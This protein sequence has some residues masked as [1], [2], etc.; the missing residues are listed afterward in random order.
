MRWYLGFLFFIALF[1][2]CDDGEIIVTTFEF[3]EEEFKMCSTERNKVLYHI[4]NDNVFETLSLE[5]TSPQFSTKA[6]ELVLNDAPLTISLSS[7]N[8]IIYRTY[9]GPL[10]IGNNAYFCTDVPPANP[11]VL[12]EYV[13]QGGTIIINTV[14]VFKRLSDSRLDHDGD[15]IA[16]EDEGMNENRDTD[17]DGIMD[18]LDPDDDGDNVLTSTEIITNINDPVANGYLDTDEDGI[19]NYLDTD[20]DGDDV[21]T[22]LEVTSGN[23]KPSEN[24]NAGNTMPRYLDRFAT[25]RFT[26][27]VDNQIENNIQVSYRSNVEVRNLKLKNQGGD[28]EEISFTSKNLG[29]FT[30]GFVLTPVVPATPEN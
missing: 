28:G 7:S 25:E 9:D 17:G 6:G 1:T 4:N 21:P 11:K 16:S 20:D 24:F 3:E 29:T 2:S 8:R 27:T 19:P 26:G 15:G 22:R 18:Y 30:S 10:P 14:K 13:S 23:L 12:Q 5:L